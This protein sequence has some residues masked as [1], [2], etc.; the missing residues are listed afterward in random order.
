MSCYI[1]LQLLRHFYGL[2][3]EIFI[4]QLQHLVGDDVCVQVM[5]L[6]L[7]E[8]NLSATGGAVSTMHQRTTAEATYQRKAEQVLSEEN[9]FKI[10]FVSFLQYFI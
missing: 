6:F 9:C 7:E 2:V 5:N 8:R 1:Q 10:K 4:L 3:I